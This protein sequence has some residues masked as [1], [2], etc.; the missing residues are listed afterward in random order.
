[1]LDLSTDVYDW[2]QPPPS[3]NSRRLFDS[4]GTLVSVTDTG[5]SQ[6]D[7]QRSS[8]IQHPHP[9]GRSLHPAS[10]DCLPGYILC[11]RVRGKASRFGCRGKTCSPLCALDVFPTSAHITST[12]RGKMTWRA[13]APSIGQTGGPL[14]PCYRLHGARHCVECTGGQASPAPCVVRVRAR[15]CACVLCLGGVGGAPC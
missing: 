15:V 4:M 12:G 13:Q 10:I 9:T 6:D 14:A 8:G 2:I 7:M 5:V 11:G 3:E 1:M